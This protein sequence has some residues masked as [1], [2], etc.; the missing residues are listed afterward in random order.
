MTEKRTFFLNHRQ[1]RAGAAHFAYNAPDGW[2]VTFSE[3]K[4]NLAQ[5]AKF[6]AIA[7]DLA[8]SEVL[9]A[10][11]RRTLEQ[12]KVLLVSGHAIAT[13]QGSEIVSGLEGELVNLRESTADMSKAR[14]AS[15]IEYALAF[16]AMHGVRLS[17][18][19]RQDEAAHA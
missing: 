18:T 5:N 2:K 13:Q 4:R 16:C 8:K 1:A 11:K 7:G 15:L 6:H 10:G 12:W 17:A 19:S 14:S 3:P 9:F